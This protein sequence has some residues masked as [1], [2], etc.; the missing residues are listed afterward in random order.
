MLTRTSLF[1]LALTATSLSA[2][3]AIPDGLFANTKHSW[4]FT[5]W[6]PGLYAYTREA[7]IGT[8][9][10]YL[11]AYTAASSLLG[12]L[13]DT[14]N[15]AKYEALTRKA[16]AVAQAAFRDPN[17]GTY[18]T[19]WQAQ[20]ARHSHP[21]RLSRKDRHLE[22][23]PLPRQA[24]RPHRPD[25]QPLLQRLPPQCHVRHEP[26]PASP[27]LAPPI[28]GRHVGRTHQSRPL[29]DIRPQ[30]PSVR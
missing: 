18:G 21:R 19:T 17:T 5:D 13:G 26:P 11:R 4:L 28:L 7:T 2:Q 10:Q 9:L 29:S 1:A 15:A 14:A 23:R 22:Q 6:A 8:Q 24:G 16:S 3:S 12:D 20:H 30:S 25:H 27:Q